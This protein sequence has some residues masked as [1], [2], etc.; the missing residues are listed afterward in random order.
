MPCVRLRDTPEDTC[1]PF[2]LDRMPR[3]RRLLLR[4]SLGMAHRPH[5]MGSLVDSGAHR[6]SLCR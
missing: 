4:H 6:K 5:G 2:M 1:S 3:Y